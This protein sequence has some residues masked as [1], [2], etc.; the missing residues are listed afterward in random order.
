[1]PANIAITNLSNILLISVGSILTIKGY[2]TVGSILAFLSYSRMFRRPIN[3]LAVI[4][5]SI[6]SA[7]AGAERIFA[8]IDQEIEIKDVDYPIELGNVKGNVEFIDV[9]FGYRQKIGPEK[10]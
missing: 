4:Y 5:T 6:Q 8:I 1:M 10:Y 9:S 3:Q 7:L 2:A